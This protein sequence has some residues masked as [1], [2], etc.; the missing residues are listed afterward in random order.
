ML[1]RTYGAPRASWA[2]CGSADRPGHNPRL[3]Q[4]GCAAAHQ[5][6]RLSERSGTPGAGARGPRVLPRADRQR[7]GPLRGSRARTCAAP[8]PRCHRH[9]ATDRPV[10]SPVPRRGLSLGDRPDASPPRPRRDFERVG[11]AARRARGQRTRA[12]GAREP[13]APCGRGAPDRAAPARLSGSNSNPERGPPQA[14]PCQFPPPFLV[15]GVAPRRTGELSAA[16]AGHARAGR[17]LRQ[18]RGD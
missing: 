11:S 10:D 12:R 14:H 7:R 13:V 18:D 1:F 9:R 6:L 3:R 5:R 8:R 2:R 4:I 16:S 17:L 15:G